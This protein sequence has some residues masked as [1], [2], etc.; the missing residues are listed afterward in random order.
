MEKRKNKLT[1]AQQVRRDNILVEYLYNHKGAE[2]AAS[3]YDIASYLEA[4]G[5]KQKLGTV[6]SLIRRIT[7]E[8]YLPICSINGK[9][10]YW[11]SSKADVQ[12]AIADLEG[13]VAALTEHIDRLKMFLFE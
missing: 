13:R 8:R 10:Y 9:G 4:Q 2:N 3:Q 11:A 7:K 5:Y 12:A 6:A 1:E